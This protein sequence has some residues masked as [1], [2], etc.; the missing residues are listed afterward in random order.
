MNYFQRRITPWLVGVLLVAGLSCASAE[1][2]KKEKGAGK[3]SVVRLSSIE[4]PIGPLT[5][6]WVENEL[7]KGRSVVLTNSY[8]FQ[9]MKSAS[10]ESQKKLE[11]TLLFPLLKK[12][13]K[14]W[15]KAS[16]DE[17]TALLFGVPL[18]ILSNEPGVELP[19]AARKQVDTI[20]SH[21]LFTP[22]GHYTDSEAL[23]KYFRAMQYLAKA[24]VD[25][26]V[27]KASFPF[28]PE[29][30]YPFETAES[31]RKLFSDPANQELLQDWM[32]IHQFY[33]RVNGAADVPT[34]VD[35]QDAS[36]G[37][38][39]AKEA[40][41]AWA[42]KRGLPRINREA[43]LGIQPLGERQSLHQEV[44][45]QF[46]REL[47]KH[48][49][50]RPVI[51]K[52]LAFKNLLAGGIYEGRS[53]KGLDERVDA[54][55]TASYY[56]GT[57][58]AVSL[59]AS[60]WK[61]QPV[62]Q[63][64]YAAALTSLAEQTALMTKT[65]VLVRKSASARTIPDGLKLYFEADSER[66]L[67]AL[68]EASESMANACVEVAGGISGET[69]KNTWSRGVPEALESFARL[70]KAHKPLVTG[71]PEWKE[72]GG[73]VRTLARRPAVIID[74][75]QVKERGGNMYFLQWG[76][77][78]FEAEYAIAGV[79]EKPRGMVTIFFEAWNDQILKGSKAP[80]TNLHWQSR[81]LEGKLEELPSI[82]R[83]G[84]S[85]EVK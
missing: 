69:D 65:S 80:L 85:E 47:L 46:K 77:A 30:L 76:I 31:V 20:K 74:V 3:P 62:R 61:D 42:E 70:A 82:V 28:P 41:R 63:N 22:R 79:T 14:G 19:D 4:G 40:V 44:I 24:T 67:K 6:N 48:D 84:K 1:P 59:G 54:D 78:P 43:G 52:R 75:F 7:L 10:Q 57:L 56:A 72:Y 58:R 18:L 33:T 9:V 66:F 68:A 13:L 73:I 25:V 11:E 17:Q 50:P 51:A 29:M 8:L 64:F 21:P 37:K 15:V 81:L 53:I 35:L 16:S 45:D 12:T 38:A 2:E 49:T 36:A 34:F 26:A 71:S 39:L 23:R 60:G 55:Q 32:L 27:K 83:W 5:Q